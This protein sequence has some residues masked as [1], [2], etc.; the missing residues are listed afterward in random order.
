V[1]YPSENA[2]DNRS[3]THAFMGGGFLPTMVKQWNKKIIACVIRGISVMN[4]T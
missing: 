4:A 3:P 1:V 2:C